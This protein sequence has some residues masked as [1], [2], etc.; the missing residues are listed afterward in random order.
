MLVHVFLPQT[1]N[2]IID[3]PFLE[4]TSVPMV[5][6]CFDNCTWMWP[7]SIA[8]IDGARATFEVQRN[9]V[10]GT[11]EY[12]EVVITM[13]DTAKVLISAFVQEEPFVR[14]YFLKK[15]DSRDSEWRP[16]LNIT[17]D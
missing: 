3:V 5:R 10:W 13:S 9:T 2:D 4:D 12:G 15:W 7:P 17:E 6:F 11:V 14:L 8:T 16:Y 1:R